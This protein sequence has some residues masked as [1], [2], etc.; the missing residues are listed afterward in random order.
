MT[1]LGFLELWLPILSGKLKFIFAYMPP[2][3]RPGNLQPLKRELIYRQI[4]RLYTGTGR[5][6]SVICVFPQTRR[7]WRR[8]ASGEVW[9]DCNWGGGA[10]DGAAKDPLFMMEMR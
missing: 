4:S 3:L 9:R 1:P 10:D 7:L 5:A 2:S 8:A 6:G